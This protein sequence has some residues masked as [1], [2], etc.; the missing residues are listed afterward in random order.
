MD[1]EK[2]GMVLTRLRKERGETAFDVANAVGIS[3]SAVYMYENGIRI[4]RDEIKIELS[5]HFNVPVE[6]IFF[7]N[8]LHV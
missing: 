6:E 8:K 7:A 4:P 5:K 3:Q 1:K 2:I